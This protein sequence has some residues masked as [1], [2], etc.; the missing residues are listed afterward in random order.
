[1]SAPVTTVDVTVSNTGCITCSPDPVVVKSRNTLVNFR[2]RTQGFSFRDRDAIVVSDPSSQF[3]YPS[4]TVKPTQATLL[5]VDNQKSSFAYNV[6]VV[7]Q[8]TGRVITG[9]P[10]IQNDPD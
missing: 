1:M 10:T 2:L 3:P 4:W 8:S 6:Y 7:D 5:D 9:D